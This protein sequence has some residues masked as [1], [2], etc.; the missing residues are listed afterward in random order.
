MILGCK[1]LGDKDFV[2][3]LFWNQDRTLNAG[4]RKAG[5]K[6]FGYFYSAGFGIKI[7]DI[8]YPTLDGSD[9]LCLLEWTG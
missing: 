4:A 9:W 8:F 1:V 6:F 7:W 3:F 5:I 2:L